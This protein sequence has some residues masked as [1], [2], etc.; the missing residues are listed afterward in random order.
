MSYG[1]YQSKSLQMN[2]AI[3][4][5]YSQYAQMQQPAVVQ[6]PVRS[7]N[8]ST[9]L[10]IGLGLFGLIFKDQISELVSGLGRRQHSGTPN[11]SNG[12]R[13]NN[14]GGASAGGG[15]STVTR[16]EPWTTQKFVPSYYGSVGA[17]ERTGYRTSDQTRYHN[18]QVYFKEGDEYSLAFLD[19]RRHLT[20]G[21]ANSLQEAINIQKNRGYTAVQTTNNPLDCVEEGERTMRAQQSG[22]YEGFKLEDNDRVGDDVVRHVIFVAPNKTTVRTQDCDN[23]WTDKEINLEGEVALNK[24]FYND[25]MKVDGA[26]FHHVNTFDPAAIEAE[27]AKVKQEI[28]AHQKTEDGRPIRHEVVVQMLPLHGVNRDNYKMGMGTTRNVD[29]AIEEDKLKQ[30]VA[31]NFGGDNVLPIVMADACYSGNLVD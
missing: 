17:S 13:A 2:Q 21:T 11:T 14:G 1:D 12:G 28:D 10:I 30:L 26:H 25:K 6:A 9:G 19:I 18:G 5:Y 29:P 23:N 27:M 7:K 31:E 4:Q 3:Q 8:N 16:H 22:N 24:E 15:A 20:D